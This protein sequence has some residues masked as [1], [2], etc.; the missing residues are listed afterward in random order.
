MVGTSPHGRNGEELVFST[1]KFP[2][3]KTS[4]FSLDAK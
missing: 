4:A 2:D 1:G 3:R